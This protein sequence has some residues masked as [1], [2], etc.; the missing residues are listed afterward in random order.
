MSEEN[1]RK[2]PTL[3]KKTVKDRRITK[4]E[5]EKKI[6]ELVRENE[7]L[8][9]RTGA[10]LRENAQEYRHLFLSP[11]LALHVCEL[12]WDESGKP[13][14]N[15]ILDVNPAYERRSGLRREEVVGKRTKEVLPVVEQVWLG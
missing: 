5:L 9:E 12:V 6:A 10:A 11:G 4:E 15:I 13:T 7:L 2:T 8:R 14:D 1:R 3:R